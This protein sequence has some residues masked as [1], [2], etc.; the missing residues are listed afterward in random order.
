[1]NPLHFPSKAEVKT[2]FSNIDDLSVVHTQFLDKLDKQ[3]TSHTGRNI[4]SCF[5]EA[6]RC[7]AGLCAGLQL[8]VFLSFLSPISLFFRLG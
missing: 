8:E 7:C 3:L 1:M 5:L 2:I 6:V 4:S